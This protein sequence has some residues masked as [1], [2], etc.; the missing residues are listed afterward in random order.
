M[1][2]EYRDRYIIITL[3]KTPPWYY[4]QYKKHHGEFPY[5][6]ELEG[7]LIRHIPLEVDAQKV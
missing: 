6:T 5:R 7:G 3:L 1:S 2:D 4:R